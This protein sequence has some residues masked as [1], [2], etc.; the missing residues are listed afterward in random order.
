MRLALPLLA[1]FASLTFAG[2]A[3]A[4]S[5]DFNDGTIGPQWSL[6]VD[7]PASLNLAETG[8]RLVVTATT[9]GNANNDALYLSNGPSGFRLSTTADFSLSIDYRFSQP[10]ASAGSGAALGLVF[11]IGRDLDGTD[12]AAVGYGYATVGPVTLGA[13]AFGYRV[14]DVQTTSAPGFSAANTG[15]ATLSYA[16]AGDLLTAT[17][18]GVAPYTLAGTVRGVW[19]ADA[20]YVSFGARGSGLATSGG[21]ATLDNFTIN[22]GTVVPVPEPTFAAFVSMGLLALRRRR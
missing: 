16:A 6:V 10:A 8:G 20:V 17:L 3:L 1:T 13:S 14:D 5:D 18:P 9:G 2:T 4:Q 15:T 19:G 12:S 22:S 21:G 7:D 11:G